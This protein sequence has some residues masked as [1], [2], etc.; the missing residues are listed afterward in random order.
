[1]SKSFTSK[2]L[3]SGVG[4]GDFLGSACRTRVALS[5]SLAVGLVT[6]SVPSF[7]TD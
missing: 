7:K 2:G 4:V 1:M 3:P 5:K 6:Y